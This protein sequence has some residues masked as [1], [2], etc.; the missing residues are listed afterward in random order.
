[1]FDPATVG[2]RWTPGAP[3]RPPTGIETVVLNGRVVVEQGRFDRRTR[4]GAVLRG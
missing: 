2:D 3:N 4:A 1:M